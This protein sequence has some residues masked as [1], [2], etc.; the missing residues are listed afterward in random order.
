MTERRRLLL[1]TAVFP[2]IAATSCYFSA[3]GSFGELSFVP[4]VVAV[5][6]SVLALLSLLRK[7]RVGFRPRLGLVL[8]TAALAFASARL[9]A[10]YRTAQWRSWEA[11]GRSALVG[12]VAPILSYRHTFNASAEDEAVLAG[13]RGRFVVVDFW[14][15]WCPPCL[16]AMPRL[17][18]LQSRF[19][20]RL[21]VVGVTSLADGDSAA[22]LARIQRVAAAHGAHYP[23]VVADTDRN[24]SNF[25]VEGLPTV[26]IVGP[27]GRVLDYLVA[28]DRDVVDDAIREI[29]TRLA[30]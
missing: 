22:G 3:R 11:K 20:D 1:G 5:V 29:S 21:L 24:D 7:P 16:E 26:V 18:A 25:Q 30:R 17:D 9:E 8:L 10:S 13:F 12:Q 4:K 28:D 14:A 23:I 6:C 2:A 15:T 27:S 19:P